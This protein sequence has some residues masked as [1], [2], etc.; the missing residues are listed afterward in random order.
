MHPGSVVNTNRSGPNSF[1]ASL[2]KPRNH[3]K[4][5]RIPKESIMNRK[6][7]VAVLS[8]LLF[9]APAVA[10]SANTESMFPSDAEASYA[11]APTDTYADQQARKNGGEASEVWGVGKRQGPQ[12][13]DAFPFG[14]GQIDD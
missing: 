6:S 14:G 1:S 8:V 7:R 4:G 13:H 11:L 9:A 12:P 2:V 10:T 3:F 5:V